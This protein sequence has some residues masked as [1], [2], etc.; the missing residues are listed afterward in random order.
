MAQK[1]KKCVEYTFVDI[2]D[3]DR[4]K[5]LKVTR[6]CDFCRK[7]K[8]KCD[9]GIPGSGTCSNC[10]KSNNICIFSSASTT[11]HVQSSK[12]MRQHVNTLSID[13]RGC[14]EYEKDMAN[15]HVLPSNSLLPSYSRDVELDLF[16][17]YFTYVHPN[18][19]I[20]NK[21]ELLQA[22]N[23]S[24]S[25]VSNSL[26]WSIMAIA[27]HIQRMGWTHQYYSHE[28]QLP[29]TMDYTTSLA[30]YHHAWNH[31]DH[32]P[33]LETAQTL[34][35]LYKYHE[36]V[37]PVGTQLSA[38][39][40][41]LLKNAQS[42][43]SQIQTWAPDTEYL[44]R[45]HWVLFL[46]L[47]LSNLPDNRLRLL[48]S[49]CATS[50]P[51]PVATQ[52]EQYN[53]DTDTIYH[54]NDLIKIVLIFSQIIKFIS[55]N[56]SLLY[57]YHKYAGHPELLELSSQ[58]N[59][60]N[61]SPHP[62]SQKDLNYKQSPVIDYTRLIYSLTDVLITLHISDSKDILVKKL[63]AYY[64]A[65]YAFTFGKD[66]MQ[67]HLSRQL[68][69]QGNRILSLGL[70][71]L[72]QIPQLPQ[73]GSHAGIRQLYHD[74]VSNIFE[75]FDQL[76]L[77]TSLFTEVQNHRNPVIHQKQEV[78]QENIHRN[79]L[80]YHEYNDQ[81][82]D[83]MPVIMNNVHT[84][85]PM[86]TTIDHNPSQVHTW[87]NYSHQNWNTSNNILYEHNLW[88]TPS[89]TSSRTL[90][91]SDSS[92]PSLI[93]NCHDEDTV[94]MPLTPTSDI[95]TEKEDSYFHQPAMMSFHSNDPTML[96]STLPVHYGNHFSY[97]ISPC[98]K[99]N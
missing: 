5:K 10:M 45:L 48:Y 16:Q 50:F 53:N 47:S 34:L 49:Y 74:H 65:A 69:I 43:L 28:P 82:P 59:Q 6:A 24:N 19:P 98:G 96:L 14:C 88:D 91:L 42:V 94:T 31:L 18:Y 85:T 66:R 63:R 51:L 22:I 54:L 57:S 25:N 37:T 4:Y 36:I 64:S 60:L 56:A 99:N 21:Y 78:P 23:Y 90:P 92:M 81:L 11:K 41:S 75:M 8:S 1:K 17:V 40:V 29:N 70:T 13:S 55:D 33:S 15:V 58:L 35:L 62:Y 73:Y 39:A 7:R 3:P 61:Q 89:Y 77:S 30:Y 67:A 27:L 2:N 71:L 52:M 87:S 79:A 26:R 86:N 44:H 32:T 12:P 97:Y 83:C 80:D 93:N 68:A 84:M 9:I 38:K 20:L 46:N 72:L 76:P 95:H